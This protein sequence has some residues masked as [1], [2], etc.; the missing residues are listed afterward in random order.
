[1]LSFYARRPY[2]K[3]MCPS[4]AILILQTTSTRFPLIAIIDI[5]IG[6][7]R[8]DGQLNRFDICI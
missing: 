2:F 1:M 5:L 6:E 7:Y 4:L 8:E 3:G